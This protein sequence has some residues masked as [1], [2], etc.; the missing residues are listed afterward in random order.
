MQPSEVRSLV[1]L[2]FAPNTPGRGIATARY[3]LVGFGGGVVRFVSATGQRSDMPVDRFA[4]AFCSELVIDDA[5]EVR[6]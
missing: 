5:P 3:R 4:S 6:K 2:W 1:G